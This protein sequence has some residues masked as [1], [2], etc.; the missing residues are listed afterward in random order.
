MK[1]F[2]FIL[3]SCCM[4]TSKA[5]IAGLLP[6]NTRVIYNSYESSRSFIVVNK[7]HYPVLVQAWVDDGAGDPNTKQAP[8]LINPPVFKMQSGA[9]QV[10][11]I[12]YTGEKQD[13]DQ[14]SQF[15]LNLYEVPGKSSVF[16][17]S[18]T[19]NQLDLTMQTQL[20]L[21]YR[22]KKVPK[23]DLQAVAAQLKFSFKTIDGQQYLISENPSTY[24]ISFS[25]ITLRSDQHS[26]PV[27][28]NLEQ[29]LAPKS[30]QVYP[31][32]HIPDQMKQIDFSL[33]GDDGFAYSFKYL[34]YKFK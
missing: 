8:F 16:T 21:F 3:I 6:E 28:A 10:L 7:N 27:Q 14:E 12:I 13:T 1:I 23:M 34:Y 31:I 32:D 19:D 26:I 20:K 22:P 33:I 2:C 18:N 11:K 9:V 5:A 29:M 30:R 24:F 4:Y 17:G 15:W 25:E